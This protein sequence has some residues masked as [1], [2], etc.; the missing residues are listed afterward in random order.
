MLLP[1]PRWRT[2]QQWTTLAGTPASRRPQALAGHP[3]G[4]GGASRSPEITGVWTP[5]WFY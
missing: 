3:N 5:V 1:G 2:L 4:V